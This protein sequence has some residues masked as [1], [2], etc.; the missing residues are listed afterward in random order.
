VHVDAALRR[1]AEDGNRIAA[2]ADAGHARAHLRG[3]IS[4][5]LNLLGPDEVDQAGAL[6]AAVDAAARDVKELSSMLDDDLERER[7]D[8]R[9]DDLS[10]YA[11]GYART[12]GVEHVDASSTLRLNLARMTAVA[13][14]PTGPKW[15]PTIGSGSNWVGYH[16]AI[17]LGLHRYLADNDRPVPR[18]LMIDQ[19]TQAF[20]PE[21]TDPEA[22]PGAEDL[23]RVAVRTMFHTL[24][25]AVTPDGAEPV[26]IIVCDHA[27]LRDEQWFMDAI[28]YDWR[29]PD[30][31]VPADWLD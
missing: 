23:D 7:V 25:E 28:R 9:L 5:Y 29:G 11:T 27:K 6:Q 17:H 16:L 13:R 24:S 20:Y 8:A 26:Q 21:D 4:E 2:L 12:L 15:L 14:T 1:L 22:P 31:L 18:F 10:T 30:G 3:R 19:P